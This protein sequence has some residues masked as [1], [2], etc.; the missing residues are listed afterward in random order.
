MRDSMPLSK[1]STKHQVTIPKE[2]FEELRL[3]V[4]DLLEVVADK[5]RV[6]LIPQRV[7]AQAPAVRLSKK[8]QTLLLS[9][10]QKIAAINKDMINST[11][12]T[13]EEADVA[14]KA[15]LIDPDQKYWWLEEWQQGE[16]E[17]ERNYKEGNFKVFDNAKDFLK[18]LK[19]S[20]S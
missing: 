17:V 8:E 10:R 16:R 9:A 12:L 3:K 11:G 19:L 15:R 6:N 7:V 20:P 1:I 5:G 18:S 4:G 14:A 2:V 13:P